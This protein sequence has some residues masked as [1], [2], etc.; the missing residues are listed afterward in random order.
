MIELVTLGPTECHFWPCDGFLSLTSKYL[1]WSSVEY[2]A[3]KHEPS[4]DASF[5]EPYTKNTVRKMELR[6][7]FN[8]IHGW[9]GERN[10]VKK[11][12]FFFPSK[13]LAS[14]HS[15]FKISFLFSLQTTY[16]FVRQT[17][18]NL[19]PFYTFTW[20]QP[21]A[22]KFTWIG[23]AIYIYH[24]A[25]YKHTCKNESTECIVFKSLV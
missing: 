12:L 1:E 9:K 25:V 6:A 18:Y 13:Q 5:L 2:D 14:R 10:G 20:I 4:R 15:A 8:L 21:Y 11:P 19:K 22:M 23:V 16:W 17:I 24:A 3:T 7:V